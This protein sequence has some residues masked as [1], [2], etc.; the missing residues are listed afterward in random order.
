MLENQTPLFRF[1]VQLGDDALIISQRLS[2]WCGHGPVLEQDIAITNIT[3]DILGQARLWYQL[4]CDHSTTFNNEDDLAY[5]RDARNMSNLLLTE[6][7]NG[8]WGQTIMR[9][10]L[11]DAFKKMYYTALEQ[12]NHASISE[13]AHKCKVETTY[14]HKWSSEWVKRLSLGSDEGH[15]RMQNALNQLW[16]FHQE[17]T[18]SS[19]VDIAIS[20]EGIGILPSEIKETYEAQ[21]TQHLVAC[22]LTI[23]ADLQSVTGGRKGIHTEHLGYILAEMQ[24]MQRVYPNLQW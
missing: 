7:P 3:L 13:I 23:P 22:N 11:Y 18:M 5:L 15:Q 24:Y 14:H 20:S 12:S 17:L 9:Q 21:I 19:D 8:D 1:L 10:Y 2:E 16:R 6:Q 4:A